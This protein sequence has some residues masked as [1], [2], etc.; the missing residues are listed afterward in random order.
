MKKENKHIHKLPQVVFYSFSG[1]SLLKSF[2][3]MA[4]LR[5]GSHSPLVNDECSDD[6]FRCSFTRILIVSVLRFNR[7][8]LVFLRK[9]H[10][11]T[12]I[13]QSNKQPYKI[14]NLYHTFSFIS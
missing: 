10:Y 4:M 7:Y 12:Q 13:Q 5:I 2:L 6:W 1:L 3:L 9:I 14:E 8:R 11:K